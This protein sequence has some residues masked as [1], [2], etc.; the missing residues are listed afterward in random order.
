MIT[1]LSTFV[2]S[3]KIHTLAKP[4]YDMMQAR[5]I[6]LILQTGCTCVITGLNEDG[7]LLAAGGVGAAIAGLA[8]TALLASACS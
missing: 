1:D 3:Q 7:L 6:L 4:K 5:N 8:G 2:E